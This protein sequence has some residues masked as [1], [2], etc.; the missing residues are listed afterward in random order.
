MNKRGQPPVYR[1][2]VGNG[3]GNPEKNECEFLK[4]EKRTVT[5]VND[6]RV[7]HSFLTKQ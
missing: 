4:E 2:T 6:V 5:S 7:R 1:R 3:G